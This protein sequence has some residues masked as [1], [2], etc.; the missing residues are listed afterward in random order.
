M[1][2]TLLGFIR[3]ELLQT[4]RDPR[5]RFVLILVPVVQLVLFGFAI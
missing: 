5:M 3:K 4:L 1:N 2:P